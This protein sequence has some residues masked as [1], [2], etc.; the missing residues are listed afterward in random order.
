MVAEVVLIEPA[1]NVIVG[2]CRR[3]VLS[4]FVCDETRD[5]RVA[6]S[7]LYYFLVV[8]SQYTYYITL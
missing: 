4:M 7:G 1:L 8:I 2:G 6:I 5:E 3:S